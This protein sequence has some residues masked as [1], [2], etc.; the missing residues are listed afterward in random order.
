MR[1]PRLHRQRPVRDRVRP[2]RGGLDLVRREQCRPEDSGADAVPGQA[3]AG[4]SPEPG[5]HVAR[6]ATRLAVSSSRSPARAAPPPI[7]TSSGSNVL[8]ALAMPIPTRSAQTSMIRWRGRVAV[9]GGL[10]R[11]R[12]EHRLPLRLSR[13]SA[14]SGSRAAASA[15]SR[16][17]AWPAAT[18]SS[19]PGCGKPVGAG[20]AARKD[21]GR[22][23]CVR[24][25]PRRPSRR[26]RSGR[27]A[28]YRRRPRCR[29]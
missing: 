3:D 2:A 19:D 28:R 1:V 4:P 9:L 5:H 29:S 16:S 6:S 13:P 10:D 27:P 24:T 23:E 11:L 22:Q 12:S 26:G 17:R 18:N 25:R 15:T 8:I 7:T 21:R 20:T 14:D